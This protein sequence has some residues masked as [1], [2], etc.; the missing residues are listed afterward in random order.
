M[1][2]VLVIFIFLIGLVFLYLG[3]EWTVKGG[4]RIAQLMGVRPLVVGLTIVAFG[5]SLPEFVVS[6][7]ASLEDIQKIAIGNIIGSN[8]ANVGLI[9]GLSAVL[10]PIVIHYRIIKK[11]L[12]FMIIIS[13]AFYLASL[14]LN[15]SRLDGIL[16]LTLFIA[17]LLYMVLTAKIIGEVPEENNEIGTYGKNTL[18]IIFGI[19]GLAGGSKMMVD[20]AVYIARVLGVSELVIGMTIVAIGTSLPELATSA[21][22]AV[23]GESDISVGNIIGSNIFNILF[24]I[25]IVSIIKPIPIPSHLLN[26]ELIVMLAFSVALIP[27]LL[28]KTG[29]QRYEGA[30]LL[31]GYISFSIWLYVR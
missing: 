16:L 12:Y 2:T 1:I 7:V 15:V 29:I 18:L 5:T 30:I 13:V 25:G 26:F 17:Y 6:L 24:V 27:I 10:T 9:L 14:N 8:I 4:S 31:S 11:E 22:A 20:S 23:R 19:I 28:I 3:A 21:V